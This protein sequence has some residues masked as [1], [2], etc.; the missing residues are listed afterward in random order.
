MAVHAPVF[1]VVGVEGEVALG[2][3]YA[4]RTVAVETLEPGVWIVKVG[5][6][7]PDSER[8][9][10]DPEAQASLDRALERAQ[11]ESYQETNLDELE[12]RIWGGSG[13][14]SLNPDHSSAYE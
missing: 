3:E 7:V 8:W 4:G 2:K 11:A 5:T 1:Q 13:P 9:L 12:E 10:L 14:D 6:F